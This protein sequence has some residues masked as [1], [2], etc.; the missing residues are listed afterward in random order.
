MLNV[1]ELRTKYGAIEALK[2]ISFAVGPGQVVAL[3]GAN[4]AGKSTTLNTLSGLLK[5]VGGTVTFDGRDITGWRADRVTAAGLVQVPEGR[6]MLAP[7]TVAENLLM[8]AYSRRDRAGLAAD[9]DKIY[10]R[11]PRLAERR[12]Q[13]A[14]LLSG[15]EQQMLAIG[16][17]LMATP[18]LLMLDEPS[19]GLAPLIVN[20][21]FLI[22][23]ELKE[24]G[25]TILL[26]EQ[27]A[28]KALA[29]AD[30][31]YVLERGWIV[32]EGPGPELRHDPAIVQAYLGG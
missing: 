23:E 16:R 13:A 15:G 21:V 20:E 22:L 30:Y 4:G 2:G 9:L 31:A 12:N 3:V 32:Q 27:N 19:M 24:Q 17:A 11:F 28:K 10:N 25:K 1:K 7:L 6:A 26:V 29:V 5:P 18:K 8:G 14:A